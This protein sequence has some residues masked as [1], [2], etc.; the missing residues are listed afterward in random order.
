ML[1]DAR[2]GFVD[3]TMLPYLNSGLRIE[4]ILNQTHQAQQSAP[5]FS[6]ACWT[7]FDPGSFLKCFTQPRSAKTFSFELLE[8]YL[9]NRYFWHCV[10]TINQRVLRSA[11]IQ[12]RHCHGKSG[13]WTTSLSLRPISVTFV[14]LTM[15]LLM[16]YHSRI[17]GHRFLLL[18]S[19]GWWRFNKPTIV[20]VIFLHHSTS[21]TLHWLLPLVPFCAIDRLATPSES[22]F[23][24]LS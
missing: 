21:E 18:T 14:G 4:L 24:K 3:T 17:W 19:R 5:L 9:S 10:R 7:M 12:I 15:W 20:Y 16:R 13:A 23:Q 11:P 1:T 2:T 22:C 6:N 8:T